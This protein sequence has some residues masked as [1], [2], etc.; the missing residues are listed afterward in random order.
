M[1]Q[2]NLN[3]Y[4]KKTFQK[5][6]EAESKDWKCALYPRNLEWSVPGHI[7]VY[8]LYVTDNKWIFWLNRHKIM[9][10]GKHCQNDWCPVSLT[11]SIIL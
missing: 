6:K 3:I 7:L 8:L 9:V 2:N 1:E 4:F 10:W 11:Q 5:K